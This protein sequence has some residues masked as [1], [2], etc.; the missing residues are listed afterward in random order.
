MA[1][2]ANK[3]TEN[4]KEEVNVEEMSILTEEEKEVF[5]KVKEEAPVKTESRSSATKLGIIEVAKKMNGYRKSHDAVILAFCKSR[6]FPVEGSRED[7]V[8]SLKAFGYTEK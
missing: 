1:R 5:E 6:G 3:K 8:K 4:K 7:L 2:K